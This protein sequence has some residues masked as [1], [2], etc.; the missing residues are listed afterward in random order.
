MIMNYYL[1]ILFWFHLMGISIWVG[2]SFLMPLL[3]MPTVQTLE[4]GARLQFVGA[5]SKR[6]GPITMAAIAVVVV[7]GI[8]QT[9]KLFGFAY[10]LGLNVL[11]IK[12]VVAILMMAN[13]TY[14]GMV[15]PRRA[16][17][18]APKP[19]TPPSPEF[20]KTMQQLGLHSWVQAALGVVVL[21]LVGLLTAGVGV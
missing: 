16:L 7:T 3:I 13:G 9:G 10:L 2:A 1:A 19:A 4:A 18:L 6:L 12:I 14:M 5:L 15:L 8:L 11:V 17:A 21:L 20:L